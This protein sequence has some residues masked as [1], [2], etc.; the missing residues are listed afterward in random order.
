[1]QKVQNRFFFKI[2]LLVQKDDWNIVIFK[3]PKVQIHQSTIALDGFSIKAEDFYLLF[4]FAVSGE[5]GAFI[6]T[7]DFDCVWILGGFENSEWYIT[8]LIS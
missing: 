8:G 5:T 6:Q 1:M 2:F 7:R 4:D 3:P